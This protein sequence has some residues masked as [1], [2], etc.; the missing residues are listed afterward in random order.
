MLDLSNI[1]VGLAALAA[2]AVVLLAHDWRDEYRER[3]AMRGP[4]SAREAHHLLCDWW[5]RHRH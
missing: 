1:L 5:L 3:C 2:L 4:M